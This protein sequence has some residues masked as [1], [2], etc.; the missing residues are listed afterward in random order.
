MRVSL[1]TYRT[2]E[3][4]EEAICTYRLEHKKCHSFEWLPAEELNKGGWLVSQWPSVVEDLDTIGVPSKFRKQSKFGPERQG[5]TSFTVGEDFLWVVGMYLAEGSSSSRSLTF[6]LHAEEKDFQSRI[7]SYFKNHGYSSSI[8]PSGENG[9]QVH[10][11]GSNLSDW[12]PTWLGRGCENKH[13]PEEFMR[14]PPDK[15]RFLLQGIYDG[16]GWK[17]GSEIT[18]TSEILSLQISEILHR[19]GEQPLIRRQK[20]PAAPSG[21]PRKLAYCVNWAGTG[22]QKS[23]RKG[24][25]A[26]GGKQLTKIRSIDT[27]PYEG[28]VYNLEV[29]GDHTYVVQGV[30][31]H[32]C[33]GTGILGGFEGPYDIIIAPDDG[34]RRIT[35]RDSGRT[36]EHSYEVWM[37][38]RPLVS[39]RDFI[40]KINGERYSIGAVRMPTN[41]GMILQQHFNIGHLDEQDIRYRVP[42]DDVARYVADQLAPM[43][44]PDTAPAQ[45]TDKSGIPDERERRGRTVVWENITF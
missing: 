37:G 18:Q 38:P 34:E 8:S 43:I 7:T 1:G 41:R 9:V 19:M 39:Q 13:I 25:W 30:V 22:F 10:V 33:F 27:V 20:G 2:K 29:E 24:R 11:N 6:S 36:V 3:E 4:A 26:Y 23:N 40:V 32:N 45:I 21:N 12:F 16:D 17:G 28:L 14:L 35:Q 42:L 44:P 15:Q 31:V 5:A